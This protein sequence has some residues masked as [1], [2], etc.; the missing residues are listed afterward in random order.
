MKHIERSIFCNRGRE[1]GSVAASAAV[2]SRARRGSVEIMYKMHIIMYK[3][4]KIMYK[5]PLDVPL[6]VHVGWGA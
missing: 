1:R 3:M 2:Q 4:H 5:M 6:D